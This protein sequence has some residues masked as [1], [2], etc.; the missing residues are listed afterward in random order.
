MACPSS[1]CRPSPD[2]LNLLRHPRSFAFGGEM[3]RHQR[4]AASRRKRVAFG[5]R[6]YNVNEAMEQD[7]DDDVSNEAP[8]RGLAAS[9]SAPGLLQGGPGPVARRRATRGSRAK[10]GGGGAPGSRERGG[11][12][13][14]IGALQ[15]RG[16]F[17]ATDAAGDFDEK[18]SKLANTRLHFGASI[19]LQSLVTNDVVTVKN[20]SDAKVDGTVVA[21]P[22]ADIEARD[23]ALLKMIEME[24]PGSYKGVRFGDDVRLRGRKRVIQRRFNVSVPRAIV[25]EKGSTLRER[26]ER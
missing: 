15:F 1:T 6:L 22:C 10:K 19:A 12:G 21:S 3:W 4:L 16:A 2:Q 20:S 17:E 14:G 26:S 9:A 24:D 7:D 18:F 11:G 13:S 5:Q 23:V 8:P 25:P